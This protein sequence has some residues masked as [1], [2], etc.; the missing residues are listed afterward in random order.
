MRP[1]PHQN[2]E[3]ANVRENIRYVAVLGP[4]WWTLFLPLPARERINL[5]IHIRRLWH[6]MAFGYFR[7]KLVS[8]SNKLVGW[9][10]ESA[11]PRLRKEVWN[12]NYHWWRVHWPCCL[13]SSTDTRW[14]WTRNRSRHL[15]FSSPKFDTTWQRSQ[16]N[17]QKIDKIR[18]N[19]VSMMSILW[20]RIFK[21]TILS[22]SSKS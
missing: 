5:S 12:E 16:S 8:F 19:Y 10:C 6:R 18:K 14:R 21:V 9:S 15:I 17:S 20:C 3:K 1:S 13:S 4:F 2:V 7:I 22:I 11:P